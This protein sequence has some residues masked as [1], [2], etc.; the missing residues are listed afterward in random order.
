M[1]M[2]IGG[3]KVASSISFRLPQTPTLTC[4]TSDAP[5]LPGT[6]HLKFY[7][8]NARQAARFYE[9]CSSFTTVTVVCGTEVRSHIVNGI[10]Q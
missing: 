7:I 1:V 9:Q 2:F 3:A 4:P 10:N 8:G 5:A 6:D